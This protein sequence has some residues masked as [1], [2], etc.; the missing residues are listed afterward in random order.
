MAAKAW[1][2]KQTRERENKDKNSKKEAND[3]KKY[4]R[5]EKGLASC[6]NDLRMGNLK[7]RNRY[8]NEEERK[9]KIR[10]IKKEE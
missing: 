4:S 6:S 10:T 1:R 5:E 8:L 7:R 3:E 2:K 9:E